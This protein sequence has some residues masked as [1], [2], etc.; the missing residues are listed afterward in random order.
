MIFKILSSYLLL[1]H[2]SHFLRFRSFGWTTGIKN[3]HELNSIK[4]IYLVLCAVPISILIESIARPWAQMFS[5]LCMMFNMQRLLIEFVFRIM[6]LPLRPQGH[7]NLALQIL[8][9]CSTNFR[10]SGILYYCNVRW[11]ALTRSVNSLKSSLSL[12]VTERLNFCDIIPELELGRAQQ[13]MKTPNGRE[14]MKVPCRRW[15]LAR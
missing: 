2:L 10:E 8:L 15:T 9:F 3:W 14:T 13:V 5:F 11:G 4:S 12:I 6:L 1:V 7:W